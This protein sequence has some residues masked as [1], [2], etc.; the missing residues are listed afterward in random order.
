[1]PAYRKDLIKRVAGKTNKSVKEST[2]FVNATLE[3]IRDALKEGESVR[4][5]GFGVFSVR[6]T[7]PSVRVNPQTR[8]K[9]NVPTRKRI[10]FISGKKLNDAVHVEVRSPP[11]GMHPG[12]EMVHEV[13]AITGGAVDPRVK[14]GRSKDVKS[15]RE[16]V[17]I[18]SADFPAQI[19][20]GS[21]NVL[22]FAISQRAMWVDR[23]TKMYFKVPKGSAVAHLLVSVHANDFAILDPDTRITRN[24]QRVTLNLKHPKE[25]ITGE[26]LLK[27]RYVHTTFDTIIVLRFSHKGLPVGQ[28]TMPVLVKAFGD[29][30]QEERTVTHPTHPIAHVAARANEAQAPDLIIHVTEKPNARFEIT[31]DRG[32]GRKQF[33]GRPMG[34]FPTTGNAWRYAQSILEKFHRTMSLQTNEQRQDWI[35]GL[36]ID[37]WRNLPEPFRRFYWD[38][39]HGQDLSI[40]VYSAEPYIPWELIKPE[41]EP[42]GE[43]APMLGLSYSMARWKQAS[44]FPNPLDVSDFV[45]IAPAYGE[46]SLPST[47]DE[48]AKLQRAFGARAIA[49]DYQSVK[50]LLKST[51]VQ[52][53]HFSGHGAFEPMVPENSAIHLSDRPLQPN[54]LNTATIGRTDAPLV[55]VNAC[56]VGQ[57]GW[58]LTHIGGWAEAFCDMGCSA[59]VGPYWAVSDLVSRKASILFYNALQE[60][61]TAGQAMRVIREHFTTDKEFPYSATWFAYTLHSHPNVTVTFQHPQALQA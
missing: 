24:F 53:I 30:Q 7:A 3:A 9:I 40:A 4:L 54:D 55:F 29:G 42:G 34:E 17:R 16:V 57:Q 2:E 28:I 36:G 58:S 14:P 31:V 12:D 26:F 18:A 13:R 59:F 48:I 6:D 11:A 47:Q 56:E 49:G 21:E 37:L 44:F 61:K 10:K 15:A 25:V 35:D 33:Y 19:H 43:S 45:V 1:M 22:T 51:G 60:G 41:R 20:T 23:S 8:Q 46:Q 38:E 32:R 27:A 52:V 39:V 50:Q 5:V